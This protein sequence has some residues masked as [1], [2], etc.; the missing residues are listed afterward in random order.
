MTIRRSFIG[1]SMRGL[2][3]PMNGVDFAPKGFL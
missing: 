2:D 3:N 1:F